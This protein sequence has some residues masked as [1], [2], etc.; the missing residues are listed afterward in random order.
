M[1]IVNRNGKEK[2]LIC[3][4]NI[5]RTCPFVNTHFV[6]QDL[7]CFVSKGSEDLHGQKIAL[8]KKHMSD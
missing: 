3:G 1:G 5:S 8:D 7:A 4:L 6:F 2:S